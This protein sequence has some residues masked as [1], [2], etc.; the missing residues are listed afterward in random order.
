MV[1]S[2]KAGLIVDRSNRS[3]TRK[4][5]DRDSYFPKSCDFGYGL[6]VWLLT[7]ALAPLFVNAQSL[8]SMSLDRWAKLRETERYQLNIAEK[9]YNEK[10][11]DVAIAEYDKFITLYE[12][13]EASSYAL[14][15]W[16]LC[17]VN[18][19]KANTAIKEG[20]QSV[21][22]YWPDSP[23]AVAASYLIARTYKDIGQVDKAKAAYAKVV[24][25]RPGELVAVL[26]SVD[27]IDITTIE[28]DVE[29][30]VALWKNLTFDTMRTKDTLR[31]CQTASQQLAAHYFGEAAFDDA[32][33]ALATTYADDQ[34]PDNVMA[35]ARGAI[36]RLIGD[37]AA[38]EKGES[39]VKRLIAYLL[40][41]VPADLTDD[42]R[43]QQA[44]R[45]WLHVAEAHALAKHVDQV[46][47]TYQQIEKSLGVDDE[48]LGRLAAWY[49][50]Q[51]DYDL[52]RTTYRRYVNQVE[53]LNQ[54]AYSFREQSQIDSAVA[55]YQQLVG[56]DA[57]HKVRWKAEIAATYSAAQ[58]FAEAIAVY[59]E[60]A[61]LDIENSNR[62]R[63]QV[64]YAYHSAKQYKEA[65]AHYRQC[66]NFPDNYQQMAACHRAL[67]E[68]NEAIALYAQIAAGHEASAPWAM[69]QMGNTRE[70]A[71]QKEQA[72]KQF[73]LV[74][75]KYPKDQHAS[76]AHAH[77]QTKYGISITLG[78]A[79]DK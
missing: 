71:G 33:K 29:E 55:V 66:T 4:R 70:E 44:R 50:T 12:T 1:G 19:R 48:S 27:L 37:A 16:S 79:T 68:Y 40:E 7:F 17:Q 60:L 73:Q 11:W 41:R 30:R 49:K 18:L 8:D 72:I 6:T 74:C 56:A 2:T 35:Y 23:E 62:W 36:S 32:V 21:I 78:G 25:E 47:Q 26:S 15:K 9:Y 14:L 43:K 28:N 39:L 63:Y 45:L 64:A 59:E 20:F 69:L 77:L 24:K 5:S 61:T 76:I 54:V 34:M 38:A 51:K 53:G 10:K 42:A 75:Q 52:A 13:S 57:E 67:K 3:R 46:P 65:I 31:Y 22:D 58:K